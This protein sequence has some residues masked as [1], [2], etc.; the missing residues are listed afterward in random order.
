MLSEDLY[1]GFRLLFAGL[2][3]W[4]LH[5]GGM[6]DWWLYLVIQFLGLHLIG[7]ALALHDRRRLRK[8]VRDLT[9]LSREHQAEYLARVLPGTRFHLR[10]LLRREGTAERDATAERF[11]FPASDHRLLSSVYWVLFVTLLVLAGSFYLVPGIPPVVTAALLVL[12]FLLLG[13]LFWVRRRDQYVQSTVEITPFAIRLIRH[14]LSPA[15]IMWGSS[16]RLLAHPD[17]RRLFVC[18]V[19]R[20]IVIPLDSTRLEAER[21]FQLVL[22]YLGLGP[23]ETAG[24]VSREPQVDP[25]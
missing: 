19:R 15:S 7:A 4:N 1:L 11:P 24:P 23:G 2:L 20:G 14:D 18:D 17:D 16:A 9:S 6:E 22:E 13:V 25:A 8:L 12:G 21:M 10:P 3:L 5:S